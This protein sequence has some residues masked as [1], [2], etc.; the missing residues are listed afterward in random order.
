LNDINFSAELTSV[1]FT[2]RANPDDPSKTIRRVQFQLVRD[3][4]HEVAEWLGPI[5]IS[6]LQNMQ[7]R[8][9][10]KAE[11][12]IN[13]FHGKAIF[14]G[15]SGHASADVDGITAKTKIAGTENNEREVVTFEF[16]TPI[17]SDLL[18][19]FGAAFKEHVE[20]DIRRTQQAFDLQ[21]VAG[22]VKDMAASMPKG[23]S[24]T[25]SFEGKEATLEGTGAVRE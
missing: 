22:M 18:T 14:A 23:T 3:F 20:C 12:P 1:K 5:G 7:G 25:M 4:D 17:K 9:L 2:A 10:E 8:V 16:E 21:P 19:F 6:T 13:G 24:M 11:M 15:V